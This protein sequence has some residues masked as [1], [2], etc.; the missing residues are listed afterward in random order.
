MT[1]KRSITARAHYERSAWPHSFEYKSEHYDFV[2]DIS[3]TACASQ[4]EPALEV[5]S[6]IQLAPVTPCR[7]DQSVFLPR[8]L[9]LGQA[10]YQAYSKDV[11]GRD[12]KTLLGVFFFFFYS[13]LLK[14]LVIWNCPTS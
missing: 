2:S 14:Q 11:F 12:H 1:W 7:A 5:L 4:P 3:Q 9:V 10:G 6:E 13:P 8:V